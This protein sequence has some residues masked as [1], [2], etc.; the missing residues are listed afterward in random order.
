MTDNIKKGCCEK[1]EVDN[2]YACRSCPCHLPNPTPSQ[3]SWEIEV[4]KRGSFLEKSI[5]K[6]IKSF[7]RQLLNAQR[8]EILEEVEG[9]KCDK[10]EQMS[11]KLGYRQALED[12]LT[13]LK[14]K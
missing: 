12:L 6:E 5:R 3:E 1:C 13:K 7:I 4:D 11:F 10:D 8:A 2:L 14:N 9:M